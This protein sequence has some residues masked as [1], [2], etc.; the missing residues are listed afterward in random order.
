MPGLRFFR[1][2]HILTPILSVTLGLSGCVTTKDGVQ[3]SADHSRAVSGER[4]KMG[5]SYNLNADCTAATMA[6]IKLV[7]A[8]AHGSVEFVN[9]KIFS[10]YPT[11]A[12]QIRCNS[13]KSPGVSEYYTS[14]SGYSGK[15]MY[16]VR[17]SYGEGTIKDV[18]VN[19]NVIKN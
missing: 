4:T 12:P 3:I 19:I 17:V 18:T 15:D 1:A 6:K 13:R 10:H 14:N 5:Q 11:G 9:E 16:K 2:N 7:Q 8:P